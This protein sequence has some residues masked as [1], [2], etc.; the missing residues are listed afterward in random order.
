MD[1]NPLRK[2]MM[3]TEFIARVRRAPRIPLAPF[4]LAL[5]LFLAISFLLCVGYDLVFPGGAMYHN[6]LHLLPGFTWLSWAAC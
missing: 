3:T 5:S 1:A 6:W 2:T 4:G